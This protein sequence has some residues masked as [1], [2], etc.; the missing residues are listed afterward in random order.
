MEKQYDLALADLAS[1][2]LLQPNSIQV[3]Y[4]ESVIDV[5]MGKI[6]EAKNILK[7]ILKQYPNYTDASNLLLNL[8]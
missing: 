1:L 5:Q 3:W 2:K 6:D 7:A 4:V 8:K